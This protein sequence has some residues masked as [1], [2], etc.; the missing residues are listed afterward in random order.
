M[1]FPS[2]LSS[3]G[4]SGIFGSVSEPIALIRISAVNVP[5]LVSSSQSCSSSSQL[6]PST[7]TLTRRCGRIPDRSAHSRRYSRISR[8]GE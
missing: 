1:I 3:P 8:W 2:K 6:A 5:A 7:E 4:T